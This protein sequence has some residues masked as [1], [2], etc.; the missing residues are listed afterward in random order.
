MKPIHRHLN[1]WID[2]FAASFDPGTIIP[3]SDMS[4]LGQRRTQRLL[5]GDDAA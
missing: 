5:P 1:L 2:R 3:M 4:R